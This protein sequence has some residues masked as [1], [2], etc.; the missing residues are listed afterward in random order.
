[1]F[2]SLQ[3]PFPGLI[4]SNRDQFEDYR[5]SH[6]SLLDY[7]YQYDQNLASKTD[8]TVQG[9]CPLTLERTTFTSPI[10]GGAKLD[11]GRVVPHWR[12]SQICGRGVPYADRATAHYALYVRRGQLGHCL[13][14][15]DTEILSNVIAGR[16]TSLTRGDI[17]DLPKLAAGGNTFDTI[18]VVNKIQGQLE[19]N[20]ALTQ[21]R[22]MLADKGRIV[23]SANF[24]YF[25]PHS[26]RHDTDGGVYWALGWDFLDRMRNTGMKAAQAVTFW[27]AETGYLG[28][29]NFLFEATK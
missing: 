11:D 22:K 25:E 5:A 13:Y 16:C 10:A 23:F 1:M 2:H 18:L 15:S 27:A 26:S 14:F 3:Y 4:L 24:H 28:P 20:P 21:L 29:F 6:A 19:L 17:A 7:R 8:V 9:I 12:A